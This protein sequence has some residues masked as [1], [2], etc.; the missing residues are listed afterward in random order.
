MEP[1][2]DDIPGISAF[3][4]FKMIEPLLMVIFAASSQALK[5]FPK[6][7][8]KHNIDVNCVGPALVS[9]R[10]SQLTS[11][12]QVTGI[13]MLRCLQFYLQLPQDHKCL[14]HILC[15]M[16]PFKTLLII[17]SLKL[18]KLVWNI[19]LNLVLMSLIWKSQ[20]L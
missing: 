17:H 7:M 5:L 16:G 14:I 13:N 12:V 6:R 4:A 19:L 2:L 8:E 20:I 18:W 11:K 3:G 15:H 1:P 9:R 10:I